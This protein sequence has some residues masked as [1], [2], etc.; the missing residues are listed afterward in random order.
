[1]PACAPELTC[2]QRH[3]GFGRKSGSVFAHRWVNDVPLK[4]LLERDRP[5]ASKEAEAVGTQVSNTT[6]D[7]H[8]SPFKAGVVQYTEDHAL[9]QRVEMDSF[10]RA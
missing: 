7:G 3:H 5:H 2:R 1:M 9:K 8:A 6:H 10:C 4:D